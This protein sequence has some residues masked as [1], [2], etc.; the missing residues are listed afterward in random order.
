M[1][2]RLLA[3]NNWTTPSGRPLFSYR[4][5][6][7]H[8]ANRRDPRTKS[9]WLMPVASNNRSLFGSR[10]RAGRHDN[11]EIAGHYGWDGHAGVT[12]STSALSLMIFIKHRWIRLNV[13]KA[14]PLRSFEFCVK[15][16]NESDSGWG[17]QLMKRGTWRTWRL[18][19][20]PKIQLSAE[21]CW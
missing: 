12:I 21:V 14:Y 5:L 20:T 7:V 4:L 3:N 19:S 2:S 17:F 1:A 16:S 10:M 11:S 15:A 13:G 8:A 9:G 18:Q 6:K